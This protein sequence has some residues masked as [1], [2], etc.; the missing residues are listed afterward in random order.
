MRLALTHMGNIDIAVKAIADKVGIDLIMTPPTTQ[1][2]LS[3]GV[4]HSPETVC[5]P[6][7]LQL[8]NMIEAL[9]MGA[10]TIVMPGGP[11]PCRFGYYH[12]VHERI[13]RELG[14]K[15][16]MVTQGKGIM[17]IIKHL[18]N[19]AP[20]RQLIP[21]FHFGI[22]KLKAAEELERLAHKA[23]AV[24][25]DKGQ[26]N[27]IHK[28]GRQAID[29][30]RDYRQLKQARREYRHELARLPKIT[31]PA[32]LKIGVTGEFFIVIDP[33]AN[34][35][36]EIELGKLGVEVCRSIYLSDWVRLNPFV[37]AFGLLEKAK[38]HKAAMP[39]V[40]RHLGGD[41]WQSVGE[42]VLH[43]R[44]WDGIVHLEPFGCMPEI[45][46]RNIMPSTK[47]NLPVLNIIC[48]EYTGKAGTISR[49]EAFTDMLQRKKRR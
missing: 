23:R 16:Q 25:R 39:Y 42:K 4:K 1:R 35:D 31:S 5:L 11:G 29:D 32:P 37:Y 40:S 30:A 27:R 20:L 3:L 44:D 18:T 36:I 9:E 14:Y 45:T 26:T 48:D 7:K 49:L 8:G 2:S 21:A 6:F 46:A 41:G 13:L 33:F 17:H 15:F 24:E 12:K 34:M 22:A 10:D 47:E 28:E 43:A 19:G 38:S